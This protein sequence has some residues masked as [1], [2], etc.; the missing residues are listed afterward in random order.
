MQQSKTMLISVGGAETPVIW[1]IK[2]HAPNNIIFFV[3]QI[4]RSQIST[5]IMPAIFTAIGK[6]ID[7]EFIV[8]PDEQD[9]GESTR[10]L[11]NEVPKAMTKMGLKASWPQIV[12]YTGGTKTMSAAMVWAASKYPCRFSYIG[13][14]STTAR[15]KGGLGIVMDGYEKCLIQENPWDRLAYFAINDAI[16]LFNRGQYAN[17]AEQFS[18]ITGKV[19]D[20]KAKRVF[21]ILSDIV[22]GYAQWDMFNHKTARHLLNHNLKPLTDIAETERFYLPDLKQ[23][24]KIVAENVEFLNG[25][26]PQQLS[27]FMIHDLLANALRRAQLEKKYEDATARVYSAIEK[28]AKYQLQLKYGIDNSKCPKNRIPEPLRAEYIQRYSNSPA[29]LQFG[30][31][32]SFNLLKAFDDIYAKRFF[33]REHITQHLTERNYSILG[34][35]MQSIDQDKFNALFDDAMALL[36]IKIN[37][38]PMFPNL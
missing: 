10:I 7:H 23:T 18:S 11:F 16:K 38:L 9:I 24:Q 31:I 27:W 25:L 17:A 19:T 34:H 26:K 20:N 8:S 37:A 5:K 15:S 32:A 14:N 28:I 12:D 29:T 30:V 21:A 36:N 3:S 35:G 4:S 6:L 33:D 1:S 13:A 2:H 22:E